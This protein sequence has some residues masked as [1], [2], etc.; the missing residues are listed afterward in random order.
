[1][2]NADEFTHGTHDRNRNPATPAV[3]V[4]SPVL[5]D[6]SIAYTPGISSRQSSTSTFSHGDI[7]NSLRQTAENE[8]TTGTQTYDAFGNAVSSTG[9]WA[10]P[11]QYGG[12]FG[13]QTDSDSGLKL[14]GHRYYDASTGRFLS[15][16]V[17]KDGRNW[18]AYC[19]SNPIAFA[20]PDGLYD[21][22]VE[23]IIR[24][25]LGNKAADVYK[26]D[27]TYSERVHRRLGKEQTGGP[28]DRNPNQSE[29]RVEDAARDAWGDKPLEARR[30]VPSN[31]LQIPLLAPGVPDMPVVAPADLWKIGFAIVVIAVVGGAVI[32]VTGGSGTPAVAVAGGLLLTGVALRE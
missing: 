13:Y 17:A 30:P 18:F 29:E 11:F 25:R 9:T 24:R 19:N 2:L 20:D 8:S 12:P 1:M 22:R 21:K 5:S 28:R 3:G 32:V 7:K 14:L 6:G 27:K 31:N 23:D 16:D 10:G 15:K 4:T 26:S